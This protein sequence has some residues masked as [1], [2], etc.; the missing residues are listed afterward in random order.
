MS[1]TPSRYQRVMSDPN[2][3]LCSTPDCGRKAWAKGLCAVCLKMLRDYGV[4]RTGWHDPAE[5]LK[6][7]TDYF[8][9]NVEKRGPDECWPWKRKPTNMGYGQ[10]RWTDRTRQA[11]RVAY[12]LA[13]DQLPEGL[14]IDHTCHDPL[15]CTQ[16]RACPHRLCCNPA[17]L[18]AVTRPV[19]LERSDQTRPGNGRNQRARC[20]EGCTCA[21]HDDRKCPPDCTCGRHRSRK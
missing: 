19:N 6:R 8:W 15:Q 5:I 1:T 20:E 18:E 4:V 7:R 12:L 2:T 3:P 11:H 13:N 9:A 14:E 10:L 21:R 16:K 17:H